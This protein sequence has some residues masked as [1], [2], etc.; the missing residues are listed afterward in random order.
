M[1]SS[2]KPLKSKLIPRSMEAGSFQIYSVQQRQLRPNL[3]T[4]KMPHPIHPTTPIV[5]AY[6]VITTILLKVMSL[7][8]KVSMNRLFKM[9]LMHPW[10]LPMARMEEML[11]VDK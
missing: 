5:K 1:P 9:P 10:L 6:A 8:C 3:L 11:Q 4:F 7:D 2:K